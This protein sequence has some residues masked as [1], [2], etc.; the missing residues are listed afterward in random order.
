MTTNV[1]YLI[2]LQVLSSPIF[3]NIYLD[4]R[5]VAYKKYDGIKKHIKHK[6]PIKYLVKIN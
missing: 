5:H 1:I 4:I 6:M 2:T 3:F